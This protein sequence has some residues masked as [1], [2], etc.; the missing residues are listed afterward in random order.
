MNLVIISS[1]FAL[2]GGI[3]IF[4]Y[5]VDLMGKSLQKVAGEKLSY[6]LRTL[7]KNK[8]S[9]ILLGA[10]ITALIQSSTGTT[11]MVVGFVNAG[12]MS[13]ESAVSVIMGANIGTT[14][15]A[16]IV[17]LSSLGD[18]MA[19][20]KPEFL[21]PLILGL[22]TIV[23]VFSKNEKTKL[24]ASV[25]FGL[26]L[27]FF[28]IS[29]MST[30]MAPFASSPVFVN[31]IKFLGNNPILGV[32]TGA[33]VT[34]ILQSS[35]ASVSILQTLSL[36][37]EITRSACIY[38]TLGQNIGTCLTALVSSINSSKNA[39]RAA[40]I[41]LFFNVAGAIIFGLAFALLTPLIEDF[42]NGSM[43]IVEISIFHTFFN[44]TNTLILAPFS[45]QIVKL[46][47]WVIKGEDETEI[48]EVDTC[49]QKL[50]DRLLSN[51]N[52]A[53]A[54]AND[55]ILHLLKYTKENLSNALLSLCDEKERQKAEEVVKC[56]QE[57]NQMTLIITQYLVKIN[58]LDLTEANRKKVEDMINIASD[59]ERIGDHAE[60]VANSAQALEKE[61]VTF[62]EFGK[63]DLNNI[64]DVTM[65]CVDQTYLY[66]ETLNPAYGA[67][68]FTY[69]Q[70]IDDLK[71]EYKVSHINRLS[72]GQC[73]I[74]AGVA[75]LDTLTNLERVTDHCKNIVEYSF[76]GFKE[77]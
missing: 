77:D 31:V 43:S 19:I 18:A 12:L 59:I 17:S 61:N 70:K 72:K 38:I 52:I 46:S 66:L 55:E 13:L 41:H 44:V 27:L 64:K 4:L 10:L 11:V 42:M 25:F 15:T 3:G 76:V 51:T 20:F 1:I 60:N 29:L 28:G 2:V 65:K 40:F 37:G 26:G 21:A 67:N 23:I 30:A 54:S 74:Y 58:N 68:V 22:S 14:L 36:S 35:A 5:G 24:K 63:A 50:D 16:W 56:E 8:F 6:L 71:D 62:S 47:K 32:L 7:T 48:S 53:I 57:I 45:E 34:I 69:E 75:F 73:N 9:G 33:I 39:K 49:K